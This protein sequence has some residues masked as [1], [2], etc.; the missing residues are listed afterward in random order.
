MSSSDS[1]PL[2]NTEK[3]AL[4]LG[5]DDAPIFNIAQTIAQTYDH[6]KTNDVYV[7]L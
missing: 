7:P 6:K 4:K 1:N 3:T 2:I 5:G